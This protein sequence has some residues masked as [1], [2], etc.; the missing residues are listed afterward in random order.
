M[1][2]LRLRI[3]FLK[4]QLVNIL[5]FMDCM[6]VATAQKVVQHRSS[7][8]YLS[9]CMWFCSSPALLSKT[10]SGLDLA[11]RL[12]FAEPWSRSKLMSLLVP[13][14]GEMNPPEVFWRPGM[15]MFVLYISISM[16]IFSLFLPQAPKPRIKDTIGWLHSHW[17]V[18][19]LKN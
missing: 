5:G 12:P 9:E 8:R 18:N 7:C 13:L 15:K 10:G 19:F 3:P 17:W 16:Y 14:P 2:S 11:C 4:G 1:L 6:S